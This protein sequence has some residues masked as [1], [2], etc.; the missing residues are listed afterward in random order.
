MLGEAAAL[1]EVGAGAEAGVNGAGEDEGAGRAELG[2]LARGSDFLAVR[3]VL[4][5]DVVNLS[6]QGGEEI[7]GDGVAGRRAVELEDADVAGVGGGEIGDGD[8]GPGGLGGVEAA[9]EGGCR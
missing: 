1:L 8:E 3:A 6:A 5:V 7:A 4:A 9:Q 2:E